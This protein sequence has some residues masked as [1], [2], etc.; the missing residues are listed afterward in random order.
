MAN[1]RLNKEKPGFTIYPNPLKED[2]RL[3]ILL[4]NAD[5]GVYTIKMY[6]MQEQ[7]V[8]HKNFRHEGGS[9]I[10]AMQAGRTLE[11]GV[12]TLQLSCDMLALDKMI[13]VQ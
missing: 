5:K 7:V 9:T 13:E 2:G 10:T 11:K 12:Y 4:T 8:L 6:N 1:V 3:H